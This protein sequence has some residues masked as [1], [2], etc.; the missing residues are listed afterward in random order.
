[1]IDSKNPAASQT[2]ARK[3]SRVLRW[4]LIILVVII[5]A[6]V[7]VGP[8]VVSSMGR[9]LIP[10]ALNEQL[11]GSAELGDFSFSWPASVK[12][13]GLAIRDRNGEKVVSLPQVTVD[14]GLLGAASGNYSA[15]VRVDRPE[16]SVRQNQDGT[17]NIAQLQR[18]PAQPQSA[19]PQP[20]PAPSAPPAEPRPA[21]QKSAPT[22]LP[23][24]HAN[25]AIRDGRLTFLA[26][27]GRRS[28]FDSLQAEI[29]IDTFDKPIHIR[30]SAMDSANGGV[31][32]DADLT[33]ATD[34]I[35]DLDRM[36]GTIGYAVERLV[37]DNIA[38]IAGAF[39]Q[40]TGLGGV[41][42]GS[43]KY[44]MA[45]MRAISG[46]GDLTIDR[47][48]VTGPAVGT[49][50][51][52]FNA[53]KLTDDLTLDANGTGKP[54]LT[55]AVDDFLT[56]GV[57]ASVERL[58]SPDGTFDAKVLLDADLKKFSASAGGL[59]K[60]K[61]G[62]RI[63]G[64]ATSD[65]RI[66]GNLDADG[67][68]RAAATIGMKLEQLSATD[69]KGKPL[70]ID[71]QMTL[72]LVAQYDAKGQSK[73][74]SCDLKAGSVTVKAG[75]GYDAKSS[76][77][78]DSFLKV[79]ANLDDLAKKLSSFMDLPVSFGG[80]VKV[81]A[82]YAG[83]GQSG[84]TT[85]D[86]VVTGLRLRTSDAKN[87]GPL[88]VR[89]SHDAT[90]DLSPGG[91]S[92]LQKLDFKS[93][94]VD[95][96]ATGTIASA[97]DAA[98]RRTNVSY[99]LT[100]NLAQ[101]Q[102]KVGDWLAGYQLAGGNVT[103][104]GTLEMTPDALTVKGDLGAPDLRVNGPTLGPAGAVMKDTRLAW[105]ATMKSA[106]QEADVRDVTVSCRSLDISGKDAAKPSHLSDL[107]F[108]GVASKLGDDVELRTFDLKSNIANGTGSASIKKLMKEGMTAN[109]NLKIDGDV[110]PLIEMARPFSE[111]LKNARGSG[112]WE[113]VATA[114]S[115]GQDL[116]LVPSLR[117]Q[118]MTLDGYGPADKPLSVQ[119][120]D[121]SLDANVL[122][123]SSG[124]GRADIK[125]CALKAPGADVGVT[126][127][128]SGFLGEG[129]QPSTTLRLDGKIE[130]N[131]ITRRLSA[132]LMGYA[133]A[134]EQVTTGMDVAMQGKRATVKGQVRAPNLTVTMPPAEA[135]GASRVVTQQNAVIDL[136]VVADSTPGAETNDFRTCKFTSNTATATVTGKTTG[137]EKMNADLKVTVDGE[138]ANVVR[139]LG[140]AMN[141][142]GYEAAGKTVANIGLKGSG[143][144]LKL[145]SQTTIDGFR[146]VVPGKN[147]GEK[148]P[149]TDPR[150]S[151]VA[152]ADIDTETQSLAIGKT[153]L[154]SKIIHGG[155]TGG[156]DNMK[157]A[158]EFKQLKG[159]FTYIPDLLG[160]VIKPWMSGTM[161]GSEERKVTFLLN[162]KINKDDLV[163]SLRATLAEGKV[164]LGQVSFAGF[165]TAG[166][167]TLDVK[168]QAITANSNMTLN[169]GTLVAASKVDLRPQADATSTLNL[170]L[171][172]GSANKEMAPLLAL[173]NPIFAVTEAGAGGLIQGLLD[174]KLDM[175]YKG[176]ITNETLNGGWDAL[177]KQGIDGS[178]RIA[179]ND[180]AV[181]GTN[182]VG[183]LLS[184]LG[185]AD[186]GAMQLD[187]IEF[188]IKQGRLFYDKAI[189]MAIAGQQ[190]TWT[191]SI[192]LDKSLDLS[193]NVPVT[194][195][196][197][198]K[199]AFLNVMKGNVIK[200]PV[201]GSSS[202]PKLKAEDVLADLA[203]QA[204]TKQLT[205]AIGD[206]LG[207]KV[208]GLGDLLGGKPKPP[209][210][211]PPTPQGGQNPVNPP[212]PGKPTSQP[213]TSGNTPPQPGAQ[214][215]NQPPPQKKPEDEIKD[216]LG[217][218]FGGEDEKKAKDVLTE[219][220]KLYTDGKKADAAKLY[221]QLADKYKK[222][223]AYKDN[224]DRVKQRA[225][226]GG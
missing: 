177:P 178:G 42:N 95:L 157:T 172:K 14:A 164:G 74:E 115:K 201:T 222:T 182:M 79:D 12:V 78:A 18:K 30:A 127:T 44:E 154:D 147:P 174:V 83:Q 71:P 84:R 103:S 114:G 210:T 121:I 161:S 7:V 160:A 189:P 65:C 209:P 180:L 41:A 39:S 183:Q 145:D 101:L 27:D 200:I 112:R 10:N 207:N 94:L 146:F 190:T 5:G 118:Q 152:N 179:I 40:V 156:I 38:A 46:K 43:G 109:G 133:L 148:V 168:N 137:K 214:P 116:E 130:P 15:T 199:Y 197:V 110:A 47:L 96:N 49:E 59:L 151:L 75:G 92:K 104:K 8:M 138:L 69:D 202:A 226:E 16:I 129:A 175:S 126:G 61:Q 90:L 194:D 191:G 28:T 215:G 218:L 135:G 171:A 66:Q 34:G 123:N 82:R 224:K 159:D 105:D 140:A 63:G 132:F 212:A 100:A 203:K 167:T 166:D 134:G 9:T 217:G 17:L 150:I 85:G 131:E 107:V 124:T 204:A 170:T 53:I 102:A 122:V 143:G 67:L 162:G 73:V 221:K 97:S 21:P 91:V 51:I 211:P 57:D 1:M 188:T 72:D 196:L 76:A 119:S 2:P 19:P 136:D 208:P 55:L 54:R 80:Q 52:T 113:L 108:K 169:G 3:K 22:K 165:Q 77:I 48:R 70:P 31:K 29:V 163:S 4:I 32:V 149:I 213:A 187:P 35:L 6:V 158:P 106:T 58:T 87:L 37:F 36:H 185:A 23:V 13:D 193:W 205:G 24:V 173:I 88:D 26:R 120:A 50:P 141:L 155:V 184:M 68:A 176:Q 117:V 125:Q 98:A 60:L 223:K 25:V 181:K 206:K 45:S 198:S 142:V 111:D 11:A 128:S 144:K 56:L 192:G 81:D 64:R 186:P 33:V 20:K 93:G 62:Y 153:Q 139:D 99:D 220:D 225:A 195:A 86:A 216:A 219:A 89:L